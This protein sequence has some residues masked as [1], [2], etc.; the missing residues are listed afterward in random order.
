[1]NE[2]QG[3]TNVEVRKGHKDQSGKPSIQGTAVPWENRRIK[4]SISFL[5]SWFQSDKNCAPVLS[6][7]STL[8][9]ILQ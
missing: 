6:G 5:L 8:P 2:E 7:K 9:E 1:M 3:I 4:L